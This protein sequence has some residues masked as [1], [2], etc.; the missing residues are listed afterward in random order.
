MSSR[1]PLRRAAHTLVALLTLLTAGAGKARADEVGAFYKGRSIAFVIGHEVGAG[2]DVYARALARHMGR[3]IPGEPVIVPQ[4]MIG[5]GGLQSASWLYNIAPGDGSAIAMFASTAMLEPVIG[6]SSMK[7]DATK[8][9]WLGNMDESVS[10]CVV[11]ARTGVATLDDLLSR[12][13]IYAGGSGAGTITVFALSMLRLLGAKGRLV[14]GYKGSTDMKLA[15]LRGEVE[16]VC[17]LSRSSLAT[18]WRDEH[19]A[20]QVKIVAQFGRQP[21]PALPEAGLAYARARNEEERQVFDLIF[22]V[23]SLGRIVAAAPAAPPA[24]V[25]AL[26]AAFNATMRDPQFLA[27]A[28][29]S[30]MDIAPTSGE[31]VQSMIV[32]LYASPAQVVERAKRVMAP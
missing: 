10:I 2:Y 20:G 28:E 30:R 16:A 22:G 14:Q 4:N 15:M 27:D 18:Q 32:S 29:K 5:G 12:E 26:R 25:K 8:M 9:H 23:A 1:K 24:R 3:H 11:A 19:A 7:F 17:G 31:M 21:N 13:T 6:S